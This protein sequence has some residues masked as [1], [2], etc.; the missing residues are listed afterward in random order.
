MRRRARNLQDHFWRFLSVIQTWELGV[1]K[2]II[3]ILILSSV[4][5]IWDFWEIGKKKV[6]RLCS[7]GY[8]GWLLLSV[9]KNLHIAS[10][11]RYMRIYSIALYFSC[12]DF[13]EKM[14]SLCL[15]IC[16]RLPTLRLVLF[17]FVYNWL[18]LCKM[19]HLDFED[20]G[21]HKCWSHFVSRR[22]SL[23][24]RCFL[25]TASEPSWIAKQSMYLSVVERC[26]CRASRK[27]KQQWAL[28]D[29]TCWISGGSSVV[30]GLL[31]SN[32]SGL[33]DCKGSGDTIEAKS[34]QSQG[35]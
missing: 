21:F 12:H 30:S 34:S 13:C 23:S 29:E 14:F 7:A 5:Q 25:L 26:S 31:T 15:V 24:F 17:C 6:L 9:F 28:G 3:F 8:F 1:C 4:F 33:A 11:I 10:V 32:D 18:M 27:Q 22:Y 2:S 20:G 35:R 19:I 16:R